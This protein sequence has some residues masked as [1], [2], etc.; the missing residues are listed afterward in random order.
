[1]DSLDDDP[2]LKHCSRACPRH[3]A[4]IPR[5]ASRSA[6]LSQIGPSACSQAVRHRFRPFHP[7]GDR[8]GRCPRADRL[9]G[10]EIMLLLCKPARA[11]LCRKRRKT[12][13]RLHGRCVLRQPCQPPRRVLV[14]RLVTG[15]AVRGWLARVLYHAPACGIRPSAHTS[16]CRL[17]PSQGHRKR[18]ESQSRRQLCPSRRRAR[19]PFTYGCTLCLVFL[20][21]KSWCPAPIQG[22][23]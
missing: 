13:R 15:L 2:W 12:R 16:P 3:T 18:N 6:D 5:K 10:I 4:T 11:G 19:S 20:R 7:G 21:P 8:S 17:G 23:P 1:M 9:D 22:S 14:A